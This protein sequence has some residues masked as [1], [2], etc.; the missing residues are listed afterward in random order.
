MFAGARAA[1][2]RRPASDRHRRR[3]DGRVLG[4]GDFVLRPTLRRATDFR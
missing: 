1:H 3:D 4:P 2:G